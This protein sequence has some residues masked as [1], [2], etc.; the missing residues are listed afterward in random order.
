MKSHAYYMAK[1]LE[2]KAKINS[3]GSSIHHKRDAK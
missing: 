3:T 2:A 1:R